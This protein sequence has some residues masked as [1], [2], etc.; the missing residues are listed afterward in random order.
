[1]ARIS[2]SGVMNLP[3]ALKGGW[4]NEQTFWLEYDEIAN[5]NTYRL[6]LTFTGEGVNVQAKERTGLFDET[7]TGRIAARNP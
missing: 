1:M 6:R 5:T 7:F 3:V 2:S 4:E